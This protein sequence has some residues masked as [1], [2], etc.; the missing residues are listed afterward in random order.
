[1]NSSSQPA[2]STAQ[3]RALLDIQRELQRMLD[4]LLK[5]E[6]AAGEQIAAVA[7][8]CAD[9]ARNL[10]HY[11]ALRSHD[12]RGLQNRLAE[13]GLSSLGRCEA[14]VRASI[15]AVMQMVA[16]ALGAATE[17]C[18]AAVVRNGDERLRE[19][20]ERLLGPA[21]LERETRIMVTMPDTAA[22]NERFV[23]DLV[24]GGMDLMRI[25]CAHDD[26]DDWKAMIRALRR[27]EAGN[28]RVCR[29]LMDLGGPKLRTADIAP[30]PA[31]LRL[32]PQRDEL[33]RV[34]QPAA[35]WLVP[36]G[37][38]TGASPSAE[39]LRV[40]D[41]LPCIPVHGRLSA[42]KAG[43][44][45]HCKDARGAQRR[46]QV[47]GSSAVG[48]RVESSKTCYVLP[49]AVLHGDDDNTLTVGDLPAR[50][51]ALALNP[52]D[53]L[54]L[55]ASSAVGGGAASLPMTDDRGGLHVGCTLPEALRALAPG[56]PVWFDDGRIGGIAELRQ[57]DAVGV[58][59]T[60]ARAGARLRA[61]KGINLPETPIAIP[62]LTAA[63]IE[64]L[65]VVAAHADLVALSFAS[66]ADDID[67][68]IDAMRTLPRR[69]AIV[70]KVETRAGFANLPSML[71]AAMR[72]GPCAV[73]IA[74]GDLAVEC[75][76][77]RLA[78]VQEELLWL[79]EAA[80]MPAIW[81][82]QV[83]DTLAREGLPSRAEITDAAMGRR[84]ECVM[85][86][87]GPHIIEA[88]RV[89]DDILRRMQ[90]HQRKKSARL[91]PLAVAERYLR[92]LRESDSGG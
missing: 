52:G 13:L 53:L 12:L 33:G 82:T 87:K 49:G 83:L 72:A 28:G 16:M 48:L 41:E 63:D 57:A 3:R 25:N 11:L 36:N 9:S 60:R 14:N 42:F 7:P 62:A 61:D 86:N 54:W 90:A 23:A 46:L 50:P 6:A 35:A 79:C 29:L 67:A 34:T 76:F 21:P 32:R 10:V 5:A 19:H 18:G 91:R 51:G 43:D 44:T 59:I 30:G 22:H 80:H 71:L 66:R 2:E 27:A 55:H 47:V 8:E 31:V 74:R 69:P 75:G 77:E 24:H 39:A 73:M 20:A 89:L 56:Q 65:Q 15:E 1:M 26:A 37:R 40:V 84:A 45:L 85:L 4:Q 38:P 17:P 68:L 81:A 78:E 70:I 58:R 88:L 64:D 92:S